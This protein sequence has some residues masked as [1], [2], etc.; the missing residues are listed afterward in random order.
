MATKKK[1]EEEVASRV[2]ATTTVD[3]NGASATIIA[4]SVD[5]DD[6]TPLIIVCDGRSFN[7]GMTAGG[8]FSRALP[9][10]TGPFEIRI[11]RKGDDTV[12]ASGVA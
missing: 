5:A 8:E 10:F 4:G 2:T 12:L 9:A 3:K 7:G 6:G 11:N 1:A